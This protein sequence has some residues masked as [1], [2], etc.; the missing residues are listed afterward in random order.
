MNKLIKQVEQWSIDKNLNEADSSKQFTKVVEEVGEVAAALARSNEDMLKDG[1]GDVV[2]TLIILA[3][4]NGMS[5]E[6]CLTQAYGEIQHR[7]GETR[8][9]VFI[10]QADL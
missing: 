4:Q 5:L 3:Q 2:V 8:D 10:K 6:E 7:K 1:I 9:G